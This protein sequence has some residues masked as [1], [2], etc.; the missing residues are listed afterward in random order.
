MFRQHLRDSIRLGFRRIH[1]QP[2]AISLR[3]RQ[4]RGKLGGYLESSEVDYTVDVWVCGKDLV[5]TFLIGDIH[6]VKVWSLSAEEFDAIE[7]DSGGV[8]EAIDNYDFVA[9]FEERESSERPDIA[10]TSMDLNVSICM[11]ESNI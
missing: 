10:G 9:M 2:G 5:E 6:L 8:V 11:Q 3:L 4:C 7:G 1:Q